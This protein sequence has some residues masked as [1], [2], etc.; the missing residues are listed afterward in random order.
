MYFLIGFYRLMSVNFGVLDWCQI[1]GEDED[2][3]EDEDEGTWKTFLPPRG[4]WTRKVLE[5]LL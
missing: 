3:D 1:C 4:T 5:P 2:E